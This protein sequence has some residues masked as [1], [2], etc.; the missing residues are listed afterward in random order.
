MRVVGVQIK[1]ASGLCTATSY[2]KID[3]QHNCSSL[4]ILQ[5]RVSKRRHIS[6]LQ[7][8]DYIEFQQYLGQSPLLA[9]LGFHVA[10]QLA[11]C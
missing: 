3:L 5:G 7:E 10:L 2:L 1:H 4:S 6:G 11:S 9:E 8:A